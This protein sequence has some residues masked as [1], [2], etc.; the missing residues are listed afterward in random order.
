L[1]GERGDV[2][3]HEGGAQVL[4]CDRSGDRIYSH[5][6]CATFRGSVDAVRRDRYANQWSRPLVQTIVID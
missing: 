4:C 5:C 2:L 1:G 3:M 6:L